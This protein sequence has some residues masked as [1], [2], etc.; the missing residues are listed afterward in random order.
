MAPLPAPERT[1]GDLEFR[2]LSELVR[3]HSG[4]HFDADTRTLFEK[5]V[6]RRVRD[7]ELTSVTAYHLHL[8]SRAQGAAEL[9]RLVDEL[10]INET[11]FFRE[12]AQLTA[13]VREIVP[14]L[15]AANEGRPV[16][17]WSAGCSS[18]EE[19]YSVVMLA[20]EAGLAPG[21]DFRV[22]ASDISQRML[23]RAREGVYREASFRETEPS[24]RERY[25]TRCEQGWRIA[26]EVRRHVD[27]IHANLFDTGKL[28]LLGALDVILCRNVIIYFDAAGKRRIIDLFHDKLRPGGYLLLGHS[29]SLI[30]LSSSFELQQ[31]RRDLVYRRPFG[32]RR[33]ALSWSEPGDADRADA[34]EIAG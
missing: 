24:V 32:A 9:A 1:M 16:K 11:Y 3:G 23:R 5:R 25:F 33:G 14:Q 18:G 27:F 8:R 10:T 15:C 12:R 20:R 4:L 31:L 29:E 19:P 6:M 30:N 7:L 21:V 17:V 13:L 34:G 22:T 28:A 2:M 26:D